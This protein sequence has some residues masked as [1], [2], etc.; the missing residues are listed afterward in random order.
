MTSNSKFSLAYYAG[1]RKIGSISLIHSQ[2]G[3]TEIIPL[4]RATESG[5]DKALKPI[6]IGLTED[7]RVILMD[8]QSKQLSLQQE[9]TVDAFPAHIYS[10]PNHPRDWFMNDGDK[11][12]GNDTLNCGDGGSSVT[13]IEQA[14]S[15]RARYLGTICVGRGHHQAAFSYPSAQAPQVPKQAYISNLKDGTISVIG[16]DAAKPESYLQVLATIDLCE[17]DKE[18]Q[19]GDNNAFPHGL[20]YS[21]VSGKVYN[22]NNGYGTIAIID[23][24]THVIEDRI[25][26]KGFSNLF[27]S[28]DGRY[29]ITRGADRKSDPQHV[30]AKLA[31]IDVTTQ[32]VVATLDLPDIY[33][34]KYYFNPEGTRLYLTTSAKGS[35]E[36]EANLKADVLLAFDI[37]QLP[38]LSLLTELSIGASGSLDFL[39]RNG[40]T[41]LIFSSYSAG[42]SV[43]VIDGQNH[44]I[45]QTI[46]VGE[47]MSHSR[48][49]LLQH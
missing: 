37:T 43:I 42:G 14:N 17:P 49:W 8:P 40:K 7:Y 22:L 46:E 6:M 13:V 1:D 25:A 47:P 24:I 29:L 5:L 12:T 3:E 34:S 44:R 28:P 39:T 23:P 41:E 35:P 9:F 27:V 16:N 18:K 21:S 2:S 48:A 45:V 10:D 11:E 19:A 32:Q 20:A 33:I 15:E 31:V 36:Q 38:K 4:Q 30:I 26:I